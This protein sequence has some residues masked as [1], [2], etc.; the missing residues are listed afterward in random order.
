MKICRKKQAQ[1]LQTACA[2][3]LPAALFAVPSGAQTPAPRKP[4]SV[5]KLAPSPIVVPPVIVPPIVLPPVA[6]PPVT[7]DAAQ[8]TGRIAQIAIKG[9]VHVTEAGI[10][11]IL[12][13][14]VGDSYD[15]QAAEKDRARI[16]D[17]GY[18]DGEVGLSAVNDP[19]GGVDVT[20]SVVENPVVKKIVFVANTPNGEPS[21]PAATLLKQMETLQ[22]NVLNVNSL[23][24]DLDKLQT[25]MRREGFIATISSD[26]NIDPVTNILTIPFIEAHI[27]RI[28]FRGLKKTRPV[29]VRREFRSKEGDVLDEKKL[30]KDVTRVYNLGLFDQVLPAEYDPLGTE[31]GKVNVII[32]LVEKRSG[33][34]T[35]GV[36]YSS[37]SKLVGRAGLSEN[38]FRGL[39]ERVSLNWEVGGVS[40][41][42]SIDI[43]FSEPYLDKHHTSLDV[44]LYDRAIYRFASSTFGGNLGNN[45]TYT[46]QRRGIT[47]GLSRPLGDTVSSGITF[48]TEAVHTND[49]TVPDNSGFI[50]Q[51]G[52]VSAL[53]GRLA[54]NTRDNEFSP[55]AGGLRIFSLEV[56]TSN[57]TTV[58]NVPSPLAPGRHIFG[59]LGLDLRQYISLQG[60]RKGDIREGKRVF[61]VRLLIGVSNRDLP[62]FEQYFLGGPDSLRG[63]QIDR[64]WGN[65]LALFQSELRLP[66]GKG[67]NFQVVALADFGDAWN[68]LYTAPGLQQ[69]TKFTPQGDYGVGVRLVTPIGPIRVDY[70][71]PTNG[72][73]GR[74]QFSIGQSF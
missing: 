49:V 32:P 26:I 44:D 42:S 52:T 39:G 72:G 62:Y 34:V 11:G 10:R 21:V 67:D 48:R 53:G 35:V 56:G 20:Y 9:I 8:P 22:G 31:I 73:G 14:K 61:A 70:A 28:E 43:A 51:D 58:N 29:V 27:N 47:L 37:R 46:E 3:V 7:P 66:F 36:G 60:K 40:S 25:A 6:A 2:F 16:K 15:P 18:F 13:Q 23:T 64:Y 41:A 68:S 74:T 4:A 65:N 5:Q 12:T 57:S 33:Q 69:H 71:I 50:R 63:Y 45:N 24:R 17:Q 19:A 55:A 30:S 38:N 59:K 1:A 54:L